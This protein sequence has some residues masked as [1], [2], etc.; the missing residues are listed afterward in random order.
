[1]TMSFDLFILISKVLLPELT[2]NHIIPASP[3]K[4]RKL[5]VK[6]GSN[7][8][9][10]QRKTFRD[11]GSRRPLLDSASDWKV[12]VDFNNSLVFPVCTGIV[13]NLRPDIVIYSETLKIIIWGELTV[14]M[15]RRIFESAIIK[16]RRYT[17]LKVSLS[18]RG[19]TVFDFTFEV[20]AIGYLGC[21]VNSFLWS[22]GFEKA[23]LGWILKR[24]SK[25]ARRSSFYIWNARHSSDWNPP[26]LFPDP[27]SLPSNS[28][29]AQSS[30]PDASP[31]EPNRKVA[32]KLSRWLDSELA[33]KT[34]RFSL[35]GLLYSHIG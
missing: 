13:T 26:S 32:S 9:Y 2:R 24:I 25:A 8:S 20:G 30:L 14:P 33:P 7:P 17:N 1:M 31:A 29:E 35:L 5:F 28:T 15:E 34:G 11:V 22:L 27:P 19:W 4:F 23:Q 10:S 12:L 6:S 18:G 16:K 3:L 21:T